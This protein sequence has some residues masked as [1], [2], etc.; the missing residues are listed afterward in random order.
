LC[1][2]FGDGVPVRDLRPRDISGYVTEKLD[3]RSAASVSRDLSILAWAVRLELLDRNPA[4][5]IPRPKIRQRKG[6]ALNPVEVQALA[7]SFQN[8]Q[9]RVVFSAFVVTGLR[10]SELQALKWGD[11]D[12]IENRLR[13][14]DSKTETGE[15][16]VAI[17]PG[18]AE[19]LWQHRRRSSYNGDGERVFCHADRGSVYTYETFSEALRAAYKTAGM[20][21]PKGMRPAMTCG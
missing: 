9:D 2:H 17:P 5:G 19:E 15:R 11:V 10:R 14:V 20:E 16:S 6:V 8:P 7:R 21:F 1:E 13:V 4:D 3:D 12:L 18:L